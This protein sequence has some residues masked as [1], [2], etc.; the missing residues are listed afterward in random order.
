MKPARPTLVTFACI[1]ALVMLPAGGARADE[2][3]GVDDGARDGDR[4]APSATRAAGAG[5]VAG[6]A[7]FSVGMVVGAVMFQDPGEG[8]SGLEAGFVLGSVMGGI[9]LPL[10]VHAGNRGR[11]KGVAVVATSLAVG[12]AGLAVAAGTGRA[13]VL[14]MT[15]V[16]QIAACTAVEMRT[17]PQARPAPVTTRAPAPRISVGAAAIDGKPGFVIAGTF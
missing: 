15:V 6:T 1:L 7:A 4:N 16:G 10:G 8:W 9:A 12:A 13:F 17:S 2:I 5:L 3:G 11:G 14:P